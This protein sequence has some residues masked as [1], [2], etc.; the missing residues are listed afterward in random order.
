M[1]SSDVLIK[2]FSAKK[3]KTKTKTKEKKSCKK[4]VEKKTTFHLSS[5]HEFE[6]AWHICYFAVLHFLFSS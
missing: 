6:A 1:L 4:P 3:T 2:N 5:R